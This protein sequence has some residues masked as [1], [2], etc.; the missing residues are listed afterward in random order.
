[1]AHRCRKIL[2]TLGFFKPISSPAVYIYTVSQK[3][4]TNFE[5]V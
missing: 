3:K 2:E 5:T 1:M 4:R